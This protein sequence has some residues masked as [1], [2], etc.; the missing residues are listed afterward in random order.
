MPSEEPGSGG[1]VLAKI[2]EDSVQN[3]C[4]Q[5]VLAVQLLRTFLGADTEVS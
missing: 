2:S 1:G 3:V 4:L 5:G